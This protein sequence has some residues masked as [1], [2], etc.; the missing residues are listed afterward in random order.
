MEEEGQGE[1]AR[2]LDIST[3]SEEERYVQVRQLTL[4]KPQKAV[5]SRKKDE[6][7]RGNMTHARRDSFIRGMSFE[8]Q[9]SSLGAERV[10]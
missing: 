4:P 6:D 8:L 9:A 1:Y 10:N 5:G 7:G 3:H 2:A